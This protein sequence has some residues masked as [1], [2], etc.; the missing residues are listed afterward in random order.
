[1]HKSK[2]KMHAFILLSLKRFFSHNVIHRNA[3]RKKKKKNHQ[4]EIALNLTLTFI[5]CL[6]GQN[7]ERNLTL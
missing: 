5:Q 3:N 7:I 1:M 6:C 2:P 4:S